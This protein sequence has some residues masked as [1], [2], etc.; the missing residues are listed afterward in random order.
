MR[1]EKGLE[2]TP[3]ASST[4]ALSLPTPRPATNLP[5]P[6]PR[7]RRR[8][9]RTR[10]PGAGRRAQAPR[11]AP[12]A[13]E[14][15]EVSGANAWIDSYLEALVRESMGIGDRGW[16]EAG[17]E[18]WVGAGAGACGFRRPPTPSSPA[19][20]RLA[21]RGDRGPGGR[22][23]AG[24]RAPN[25][26]PSRPPSSPPAS[27]PSTPAPPTATRAT[28]PVAAHRDHPPPAPAARATP[29][30]LSTPNIM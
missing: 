19:T 7:P 9:T 18:G 13:M 29:T 2:P 20:D 17:E 24:R 12:H 11:R 23:P 1:A 8:R 27:P 30:R 15:N 28:G 3:A 6:P 21:A 14:N 16:R 22:A 25:P 10:P 5:P 4:R 26:S